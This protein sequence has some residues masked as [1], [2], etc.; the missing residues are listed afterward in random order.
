MPILKSSNKINYLNTVFVVE[1]IL[2]GLII[3]GILPRSVVPYFSVAL[4]LYIIFA[5][6]EDTTIFFVRSI[7]FFLA[8]PITATFD[9]FNSWRIISG[10]IFIKWMV[11][12]QNLNQNSIYIVIRSYLGV[13]MFK[14]IS[15]PL[16]SLLLF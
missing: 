10:I 4:V 15:F 9:N 13:N 1:V 12:S 8:I 5:S 16:M 11:K 3:T 6:L 14:K 2:F 7:P